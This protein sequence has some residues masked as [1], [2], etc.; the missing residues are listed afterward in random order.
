MSEPPDDA[1]QIKFNLKETITRV[2]EN[3]FTKECALKSLEHYINFEEFLEMKKKN[4]WGVTIPIIDYTGS[5]I[6]SLK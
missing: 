5:L 2:K 3:C 6:I 1:P 4:L